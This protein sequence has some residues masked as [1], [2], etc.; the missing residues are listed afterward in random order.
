MTRSERRFLEKESVAED[1][2]GTQELVL[3]S[4]GEEADQVG[5]DIDKAKL[6]RSL[7]DE[8]ER[9]GKTPRSTRSL[10]GKRKSKRDRKHRDDGGDFFNPDAKR[11]R[12]FSSKNQL[13]A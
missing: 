7:A 11:Q 9:D 6:D 5:I 12:T 13:I 8:L 10:K 1:G 3:L 2:E 4:G